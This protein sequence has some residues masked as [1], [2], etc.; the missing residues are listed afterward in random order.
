MK[1]VV[2]A[3]LLAA[4]VCTSVFADGN[5]DSD[6][7]DEHERCVNIGLIL[8]TKVVDDANVVFFMR[9]DEMLLNTLRN[10]CRGLA[11]RG[12]FTYNINSRSLCELDRITVI[13]GGSFSEP[14]GRSCTLGRF[15]PITMEELA[16][17]FAPVI[18]EPGVEE[19]EMP[20]VEEVLE[21]DR[22]KSPREEGSPENDL[23]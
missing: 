11:R 10:R 12:S 21:G 3:P 16:R 15:R 18:P 6:Y 8:R 19:V 1:S 17:Q 5:E 4:V 7:E 14:L 23:R 13:E 22:T 9:N 2:W 20:D